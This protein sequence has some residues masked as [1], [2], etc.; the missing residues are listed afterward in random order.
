MPLDP[1]TKPLGNDLI[2]TD[3]IASTFAAPPPACAAALA[4][5]DVLEEEDLPS[6]SQRLGDLLYN[7]ISKLNPPHILAYRGKGRGLFQCLVID[8]SIPGVTGRRV[9]ALCARRGLLVGCTENRIRFSPPLTMS[10]EDIIYGAQIVDSALRDVHSF[11]DFP[12][13]DYLL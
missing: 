5:L 13:S 8:E 4:A 3:R 11:G 6:S 9:A 7:T 12:G 1:T 2:L 10:E